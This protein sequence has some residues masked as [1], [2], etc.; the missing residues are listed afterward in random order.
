MTKQE[1]NWDLYTLVGVPWTDANDL[2]KEDRNFLLAKASEIKTSI[3]EGR[4]QEEQM[5]KQMQQQ[6]QQ[7]IMQPPQQMP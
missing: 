2:S 5:R 4:K 7:G 3:M 1:E 6:A